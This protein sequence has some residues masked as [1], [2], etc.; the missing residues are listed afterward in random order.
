MKI[1]IVGCGK[2]GYALCQQL[3][4]EG[5]DITLIDKNVERLQPVVDN[6]DIQ[7]LTGNGTSFLVQ[8]EAGIENTDLLIAVTNED[9]INLITCLIAKKAGNNCRTIARVRNPQYFNEIDYLKAAMGISLSINPEYAA[10]HEIARLIQVPD[11]IDIDSFARGRVDLLRLAIPEDSPVDNMKVYEF[12]KKFNRE[13]LICILEHEHEISIPNGNSVL[14]A[15]D[16]ISIIIPRKKIASFCHTFQMSAVREIKDVMIAGGGT[17]AYYLAEILSKSGIK[18]KI[19]EKDR[20]RSHFLSLALP[21]TMII[22]ADATVHENLLEEG[23]PQMDAFVSLTT[24]DETNIFLSLFANKVAPKCKKITKMSKMAQ[25]DIIEELPIGSIISARNTTTEYI[26]KYVRSQTNAYGSN[27][28][29]LYRLM[30]NQ[31]EALEFHV[32]ENCPV[33]GI[34]L[35]NLKL[36]PNLLV[37]CIV[38]GRQIITPSGRDTIELNDTVIVVTTNKGLQ[39]ISDILQG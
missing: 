33:I 12:S 35:L 4:D 28:A 32:R 31:V 23:L 16:T 20:D 36:K 6:L 10:A 7:V 8:Q 11:A 27:V 37:C 9:E 15:G 3:N 18:V 17:T 13:V 19:M 34:P 1:I 39:D 21:K 5:H 30:D 25:D 38:R 2:V 24:Q 22:N 29:G 26:L 14:H